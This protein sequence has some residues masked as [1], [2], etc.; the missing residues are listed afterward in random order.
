MRK[1]GA[2]LVNSTLRVD[3]LNL[4]QKVLLPTYAIVAA[5]TLAFPDFPVVSAAVEMSVFVL[6]VL[7]VWWDFATFVLASKETFG[8]LVRHVKYK[9]GQVSMGTMNSKKVAQ[10]AKSLV[11]LMQILMLSAHIILLMYVLQSPFWPINLPVICKARSTDMDRYVIETVRFYVS[12]VFHVVIVV[13]T[14]ANIF[15]FTGAARRKKKRDTTQA[16]IAP[17]PSGYLNA[18]THT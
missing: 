15:I 16:A 13:N 14:W 6:T 1:M 8:L 11:S 12:D 5:L 9:T 18:T 17:P 4:V 3:Q 7:S 10:R 2:R